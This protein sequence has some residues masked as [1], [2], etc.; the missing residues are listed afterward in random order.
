V[1]LTP[2]DGGA[3]ARHQVIRRSVSAHVVVKKRTEKGMRGRPNAKDGLGQAEE[4]PCLVEERL[5][6]TPKRDGTSETAQ[7]CEDLL[8]VIPGKG[9]YARGPRV[10]THKGSVNTVDKH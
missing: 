10:R 9:T 7:A 8:S 2:R 6:S 4:T 5:D 3:S 1:R